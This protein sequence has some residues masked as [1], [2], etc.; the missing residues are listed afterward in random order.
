V[1]DTNNSQLNYVIWW[2]QNFPGRGNTV[3]YQG[4]PFR[5]WW[6]VHGEWDA[7]VS[8]NLGLTLPAS[9]VSCKISYSPSSWSGGFTANVVITN[10]GSSAINGWTVGFTFPGDEKITSFWNA[11]VTQ[12]AESVTATNTTSNATIPAG[13]NTSFGFQGTWAQSSASP[14]SFTVN[15]TTCTT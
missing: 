12:A 9:L 8:G 11:A 7:V 5:N 10:T 13:G 14:T 2:E 15:G 6:D 3:S 1:S 4:K